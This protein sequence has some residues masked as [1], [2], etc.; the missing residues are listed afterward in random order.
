MMSLAP[1]S[2]TARVFS[3]SPTQYSMASPAVTPPMEYSFQPTGFS[4][5]LWTRLPR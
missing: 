3:V 4:S 2:L 5:R 1:L